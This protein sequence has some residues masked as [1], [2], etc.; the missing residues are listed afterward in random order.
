LKDWIEAARTE[1]EELEERDA[2]FLALRA[3]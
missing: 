3:G 2:G 1:P